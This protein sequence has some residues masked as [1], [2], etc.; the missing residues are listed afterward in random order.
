[1]FDDLLAALDNLDAF[2]FQEASTDELRDVCTHPV[3]ILACEVCERLFPRSR[4][5]HHYAHPGYEKEES[6]P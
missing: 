3:F 4:P 2:D 6:C 5:H 1:M